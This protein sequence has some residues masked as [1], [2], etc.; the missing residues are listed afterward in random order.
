MCCCMTSIFS[1]P[2]YNRLV[3]VSDPLEKID[4]GGG[5]VHSSLEQARKRDRE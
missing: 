3:K 1:G 4:V 2:T 5:R